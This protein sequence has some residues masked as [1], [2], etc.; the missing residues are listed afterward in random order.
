MS[1]GK[2]TAIAIGPPVGKNPKTFKPTAYLIRR[3]G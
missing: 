2:D 1:I 3:T